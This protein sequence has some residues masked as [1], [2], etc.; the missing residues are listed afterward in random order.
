M[1]K[2]NIVILAF[3]LFVIAGMLALFIYTEQ[4]DIKNN[5]D[6]KK[7]EVKLESFKVIVVNENCNKLDIQSGKENKLIAFTKSEK[8]NFSNFYHISNDTLYFH[9]KYDLSNSIHSFVIQCNQVNTILAEKNNDI[10]ISDFTSDYL[11]I[12]GDNSNIKIGLAAIDESTG[13]GCELKDLKISLS[14]RSVFY[15]NNAKIDSF[16]YNSIR[17][18]V[19][20]WGRNMIRSAKINLNDN[21]SF[22]TVGNDIG[23]KNLV[24]SCDHSSNYKIINLPEVD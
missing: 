13:R 2:S 21:S 4:Y 17:S 12:K 1:K 23:I 10:Y 19:S 15:I 9:K 6:L 22:K 8:M 11:K 3:I 20:F 18:A 16:E 7:E 5:K 24:F 14:N